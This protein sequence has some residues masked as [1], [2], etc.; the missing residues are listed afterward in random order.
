MLDKLNKAIK[1]I[2]NMIIYDLILSIETA[3]QL[4]K[5]L[6]AF[7]YQYNDSSGNKMSFYNTIHI[8]PIND[9]GFEDF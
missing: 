4:N 5:E 8:Y 9:E 2:E 6:L 3:Y 1:T 7:D